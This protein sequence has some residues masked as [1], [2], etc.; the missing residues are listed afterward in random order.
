MP[1]AILALTL[2][3]FGIGTTEFVAMGV[4]PNVAADM[5]VSTATAGT[6]V[7]SYALGVVV[8]AP[9]LAAA[10]ARL[11]RKTMLLAMMG[12]FTLG[13]LLTVAAPDFGTLVAARVLTGLPHGAFLGIGAV[14]AADLVPRHK[15]GRAV[16]RVLLGLTLANIGGV[17][18]GT[19]LA[20][21]L[22]WRWTFAVV[23]LIGAATVA[24]IWA[25]V[26]RQEHDAGQA[27]LRGELRVFRRP[28]VWAAFA[29]VVFGFGGTFAFYTYINPML[30]DVTGFRPLLV[31]VMLAVFGLGMTAG[32]LLGG[33][34]ADRSPMRSLAL[35]LPALSAMMALFLVTAHSKPLAVVNVFLIGVTGFV[36][37][38]CIQTMILDKARE[39]PSLASSGMHSAFNVANALGSALGGAVLSAG[40]GLLAPNAVGALLALLGLALVGVLA[41]LERRGASNAPTSQPSE[42]STLG[43]GEAAPLP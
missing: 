39:A 20:Q 19:L 10:G 43:E 23:A 6:L 34:L 37:I 2:G 3:S 28:Q 35:S 16:A 21:Q 8:G 36:A 4:L 41:A 24:S 26:P 22:G 29:I 7:S 31:T 38:A 11:S 33:R 32:T 14:V 1:I 15:R 5:G 40:F 42:D 9:L 27:S 25:L 18:V 12:M 17:P 13:S 30:S